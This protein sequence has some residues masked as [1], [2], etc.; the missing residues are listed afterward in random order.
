[1]LGLGAPACAQSLGEAV[2]Q[3]L[4]TNPAVLGAVHNR[5][6]ADAAVG[7]ARG[8][9]FPRVDVLVGEG[10][11]RSNNVATI[12]LGQDWA[13]LSRH[14]ELLV[15]NQMLWDGL[16]TRSEV[17]RRTALAESSAHRLR[18]TAED[19]AMQAIDAYLEVLR[20]RELLAFA[21]DNLNAHERAYEQV[22]QRGETAADWRADPEQMETRLALTGSN[23]VSAQGAAGDAETAFARVVGEHPRDLRDPGTDITVAVDSVDHAVRIALERHSAL[24]SGDADIEAA[25]ALW[26]GARAAYHPRVELEL[27]VGNHHNIDGLPFPNRDR[28]LMLRLKWNLFR[29]GADYGR[30]AETSQLVGEASEAVSRTR[31]QV[32]SAVRLACSAYEAAHERLPL[33]EQYVAWSD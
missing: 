12:G 9:Y 25:R 13:S 17:E 6:A 7:A 27:S 1:V 5:Q 18:S 28:L 10:R 20:T 31:R 22:R 16:G 4:A 23:V 26:R 33:L 3:A 19:T 2:R 29:G 11:E 21:K 32:E 30:V 8:A 14:E 24:K 15:I